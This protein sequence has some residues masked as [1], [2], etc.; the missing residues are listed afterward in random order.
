MHLRLCEGV[1]WF[2]NGAPPVC[3]D[4]GKM[5]HLDQ[6]FHEVTYSGIFLGVGALESGGFLNDTFL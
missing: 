6:A 5:C 1:T 2:L 4:P 3:R